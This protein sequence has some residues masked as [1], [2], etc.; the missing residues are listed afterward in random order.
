MTNDEKLKDALNMLNEYAKSYQAYIQSINEQ[1][2][3]DQV[4]DDLIT[5]DELKPSMPGTTKSYISNIAHSLMSMANTLQRIE[6]KL[7]DY[8]WGDDDGE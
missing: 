3:N 6:D 8:V 2:N 1:S 4:E 5:D 7:D